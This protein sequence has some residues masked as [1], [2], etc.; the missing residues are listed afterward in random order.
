MAAKK[1]F[2]GVTDEQ[3]LKPG[4]QTKDHRSIN[5]KWND[6]LHT[7]QNMGTILFFCA[8]LIFIFP[9]IQSWIFLLASFLTI[10]ALLKKDK[11]PLKMPIQAN[12][13]DPKELGPKR[14]PQRANGIFFIGNDMKTGKEI[15]LTNSDCR[16]HFLVLG[17]TGAGKALPNNTNVL[18]PKGWFPIESLKTNDLVITPDGKSA[19]IRGV[20]PQGSLKLQRIHFQNSLHLDVSSDHL[21]EVFNKKEDKEVRSI[22]STNDILEEYIKN[23]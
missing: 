19:K 1:D 22:L 5:Q 18:T 17:T 3:E 10:K 7:K 4:S 21:W 14:V 13:I 20:Y 15:W 12:V 6:W 11:V 16:Q 8:M 2:Y 23:K 9:D